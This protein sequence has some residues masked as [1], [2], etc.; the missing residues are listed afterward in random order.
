[1]D[2]RGFL[3]TAG[4]TIATPL[5]AGC[6][7]TGGSGGGNGNAG[8]S[9]DGSGTNSG[10]GSSGGD[11]RTITVDW[12]Y[13]NP[14]SLVLRDHGWL[15]EEFADDDVS[16][17]WVLSLGS[18]QANEYS[19][20]GSAE[21]AS[22]AGIAALLARTNGVPIRTP[23]IYS[24]PEWTALVAKSDSGIEEVADLEGKRVAATRGTDPYF[25]LLQ[26]LETAGLSESDVEVVHLQHP[27]G[28]SALVQDDVDAWAGLD[29]HMAEL[30]L[31][32]DVDLFFREPDFNT[33]GFLNVLDGFLEDH[34]EDARRVLE[35]YERGRQ[36]ALENPQETAS[37]LAA[38]SDMSQAVAERVFV[39][40]NDLSTALP[41][42]QHRDLLS[43]LAPILKDEGMV[44]PDADLQA[45]IDELI[46]SET[47]REVVN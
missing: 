43:T 30:E 6:I 40:R 21:F 5:V 20:S 4:T 10:N 34:P 16:I 24:K 42:E 23:Y 38:E 36:W 28:Q 13:Y 11:G 22:T 2:R 41:G 39:E 31:E 8:G 25:F 33:Y 37:I 47:A 15:E 32:H 3:T 14:I 18:N 35:T 29:P 19:Q 9:N 17:E 45:R 46:D 1:M 44:Q 27:D 12:A 26:A 7:A